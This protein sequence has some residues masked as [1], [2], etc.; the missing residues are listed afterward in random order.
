MEVNQKE[1]H[2]PHYFD[3]LTV[4]RLRVRNLA[5]GGPDS[6][7]AA[8]SLI[9]GNGVCLLPGNGLSDTFP[10]Y[11]FRVLADTASR[12][13]N[14][15]PN[16]TWGPTVTDWTSFSSDTT[17]G[18]SGFDLTTGIWTVPFDGR[19]AIVV[20][21][22]WPADAG[23][24]PGNKARFLALHSDVAP[25]EAYDGIA[26]ASALA[27]WFDNVRMPVVR[28]LVAGQQIWVSLFS[29][30]TNAPSGASDTAVS[31]CILSVALLRAL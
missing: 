1:I 25:T 4:N 12:S 26:Q 20:H 3:N 29:A 24:G 14:E 28:D 9:V 2:D 18:T 15:A 13:N 10:N 19:F 6:V 23:N 30:G 5:V 31:R 17:G 7:A 8:G 16:N 21:G 22:T 11:A 27:S